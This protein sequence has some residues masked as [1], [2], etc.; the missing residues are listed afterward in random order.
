[1]DLAADLEALAG[2]STAPQGTQLFVDGFSGGRLPSRVS[3]RE[4]RTNQNPYSAAYDRVGFGRIEV[5][6][7]PGSD[8][9]RGETFFSFGDGDFNSRNPF[10]VFNRPVFQERLFG[11]KLSGPLN[12]RASFSADMERRELDTKAVINATVL[13]PALNVT[14]LSQEVV[15]PQRRMSIG[16]RLD[17]QWSQNHTLVGRYVTTRV[18]RR[19]VGIG[20][21]SLRARA[22]NTS[23]TD[24]VLQL[25]ETA[26][27]SSR[28]INETRLQFMRTSTDQLG[29]N[30]VPTINVSGAFIEGGSEIGQ[31]FLTQNRWELQN[32]T[33]LVRGTQT[34][35]WGGRLR[36]ISISDI[37]PQ[38]FGGTF[39][40]SGGSV[41]QL[42]ADNQVMR[43]A[44]GQPV[45]VSITP[46]ERYRRTLLFQGQGLTAAQI[47]A[48]GGGAAQFSITA[49][50]SKVELSQVDLGIF[51]QND[52][53][54]RP[55]Y[56]LSLG[57]RYETQN[58][59]HHWTDFAPRIGL[60]WAPGPLKQRKTAIRAG[61]GIFYDR[62]SEKLTLQAIRLNGLNQQQYVVRDPDFFP[63]VPRV[64]TLTAQPTIRRVAS[65][66]RAPYIMQSSIG[67]ER[68]LPF[69]TTIAS[70]FTNFRGL[71]M[72]RSRNINAPLPET[73][74]PGVSTSGIR[75]FGAGTVFLYE[76]V[77][78][79]NQRQWNTTV[80]SRFNRNLTLFALYVLN[81][82]KSNTDGPA[83][84]PADSY[85]DSME[86]GRSVLDERHRLVVG[87]SILALHGF[88]F[89]PYIVARSGA[90][91][92]VT[93]GADANGDTLL[94]DRPGFAGDL[95]GNNV[96]V[97]RFGAFDP[98]PTSEQEI[99]PRN[100]GFAPGYFTVNLCLSKSFGFGSKP[101][102][103]KGDSPPK[104]EGGMRSILAELLTEKPYNLVF[105]VSVRNLLNHTNPGPLIGSLTS[106]FFGSANSLADSYG[107][108]AGAG[109][110]RIEM[111]LRFK[112]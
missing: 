60:A 54:I 14:P 53:R 64:E 66:L 92:N 36:S 8:K 58:N 50:N 2:A 85:D 78:V 5:F 23:E 89:S 9:F 1:D 62:F 3:I 6:T 96:V 27:V 51:V 72:L 97:S 95:A 74:V 30:S 15:T 103:S 63:T 79:L 34:L 81:Y 10:Y 76:S 70:T 20:D 100:Y 25:T 38:N 106:P 55:N 102:K 68:L 7:K 99:I 39:R 110:R 65:D 33:Y 67:I 46:I 44:E 86:Y 91:F 42:D 13:D 29:N 104:D 69:N 82:A 109:N 87:G 111:Q 47:R 77:G 31:S 52:W 108:A 83:T 11:G 4:F 12:K 28:A 98:N 61:F 18:G 101:E 105:S 41:P 49:G 26:V 21:L 16:F 22:Y 93:T 73:F 37:S 24:H 45:L 112:F 19:N 57:L 84:F 48:L 35:R 17:Y 59:I 43:D 88:K 71:H 56:Q 75:P 32:N 90:P 107:P 94:T 80:N 40:F